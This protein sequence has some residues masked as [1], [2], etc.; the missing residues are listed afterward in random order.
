MRT[1]ITLEK[2][3]GMSSQKQYLRVSG[4]HMEKNVDRSHKLYTKVHLKGHIYLLE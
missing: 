4:L 2:K 1:R 3:T